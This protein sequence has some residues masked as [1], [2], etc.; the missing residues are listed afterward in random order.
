MTA[1]TNDTDDTFTTDSS[2]GEQA[3]ERKVDETAAFIEAA[4]DA[5]ESGYNTAMMGQ[6]GSG[7]ISLKNGAESDGRDNGGNQ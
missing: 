2:P 3:F 5:D 4:F 6:I 1:D 7:I